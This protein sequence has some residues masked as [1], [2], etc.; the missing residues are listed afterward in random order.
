MLSPQAALPN[1]P[2]LGDEIRAFNKAKSCQI[3]PPRIIVMTGNTDTIFDT[4]AGSA[5]GDKKVTS[6]LIVHNLG[7]NPMYLGL[8]QDATAALGAF[9]DILAG[10]SAVKDGLGSQIDL[11][12]D[13]PDWVTVKGTAGEWVAV[14]ISYPLDTIQN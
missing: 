4:R 14:V 7:A 6:K 2:S 1:F 5:F 3:D 13:Q 12:K 8:N 11:S 10:G 9:H